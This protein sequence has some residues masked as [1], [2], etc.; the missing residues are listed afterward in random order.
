MFRQVA[1]DIR[2]EEAKKLASSILSKSNLKYTNIMIDSDSSI[3]FETFG[4]VL[5][6]TNLLV[7]IE[8]PPIAFSLGEALELEQDEYIVDC[9]LY[10]NMI[11][12]INMYCNNIP[13]GKLLAYQEELRGNEDFESL[14]S[15]KAADGMKYYK[16][17]GID[18]GN[19][20]MIPMFSGFPNLNKAD[21]IG[22]K[23]FDVGNNKHLLVNMNIYKEKV[24]R[25]INMYF[26][27]IDL[28]R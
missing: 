3:Y 14:L 17:N 2:V 1:K 8:L 28:S 4:T 5:Y 19:T 7:N 20:Y 25:E 15:L 21:R 23:I 9:L 24:N 18:I 12:K 6:K 22:I 10:P 11:Q 13:T 26:V 16:V 27:T